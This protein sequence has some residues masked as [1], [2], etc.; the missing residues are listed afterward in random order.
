MRGEAGLGT[1]LV[2]FGDLLV[3]QAD[4][5]A[6]LAVFGVDTDRH[7]DPTVSERGRAFLVDEDALTTPEDTE[8]A[9]EGR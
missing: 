8:L 5:D 2:A 1:A 7:P 6:G 4:V 9:E 3:E